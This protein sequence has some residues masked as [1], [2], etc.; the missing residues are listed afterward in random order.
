MTG[1][2]ISTSDVCCVYGEQDRSRIVPRS[3]NCALQKQSSAT[4]RGIGKGRGGNEVVCIPCV[5][6]IGQICRTVDPLLDGRVIRC[7][8]TRSHPSAKTKSESAGF[9]L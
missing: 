8:L 9:L 6:I 5:Q 3:S 1:V 2:L 7:Y 4:Y